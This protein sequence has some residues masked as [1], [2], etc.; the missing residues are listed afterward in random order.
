MSTAT[1]LGSENGPPPGLLDTHIESFLTRLRAAGYAERTLRKKRWIAG[2]FARWITREHMAVADLHDRH[3]MAFVQRPPRRRASRVTFELG[4]LRPFMSYLRSEALVPP[5][6]PID[7]S[8]AADLER[9]YADFLRDE[10]GL[11]ENSL[12]VYLPRV[13][14]FLADHVAR[15]GGVSPAALDADTVQRFLLD[16]VRHRSSEYARL[17]A[18][19]LRSFSRFLYQRGETTVDLSR[20]IPTVRTWR[21]SGVPHFLAAED[22]DQRDR[23]SGSVHC[24]RASGLRDP[25]PARSAGS[26]CRR[27]GRPGDR[28]YS[29]ALRGDPHPWQGRTAR[30]LPLMADV[31]EALASPPPGRGP[32]ASRRVFLRHWARASAWRVL[33]PWARRPRAFARVKLCPSVVALPTS[34]AIAWQQP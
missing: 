32:S 31:G 22:I 26:P 20:A 25:P 6:P 23:G 10:R 17:L 4:V 33:P 34:S 2:A 28:R 3:L 7:V 19:A 18:A 24:G 29:L 5:P 15:T 13:R 1:V 8:P 11:A 16:R 9:R 14:L 27:G 30:R 12:R 21:Q